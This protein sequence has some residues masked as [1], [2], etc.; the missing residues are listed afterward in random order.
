MITQDKWIWKGLAGHF[1]LASK[2]MF[3]LHTVVGK[4]KIST[5]GACYL[6]NSN[7]MYEIGVDHHYETMVFEGDSY[8]EIDR[9]IIRKKKKDDPYEL[10]KRAEEMHMRMCLKY[11][12]IQE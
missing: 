7:E 9:E 5:V 12:E 6:E 2:C 3:R 11:A 8:S 4:Y 10:D 1:C